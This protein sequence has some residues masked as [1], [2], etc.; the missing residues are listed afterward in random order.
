MTRHDTNSK[1]STDHPPHSPVR[2]S[3]HVY[4]APMLSLA[5]LHPFCLH[6]HLPT[7]ALSVQT[8]ACLSTVCP[9]RGRRVVVMSIPVVGWCWWCWVSC[10][11]LYVFV[12]YDGRHCPISRTEQGSTVLSLTTPST[13]L[14]I[15]I[16]MWRTGEEWSE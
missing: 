12:C 13:T 16:T 14:T 6:P 15:S 4:S 10:W 7:P 2:S 11:W 8:L 3:H 1:P 9:D 5:E